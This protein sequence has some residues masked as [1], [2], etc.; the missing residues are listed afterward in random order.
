MSLR[1]VWT[2]EAMVAYD[3]IMNYLHR[4]WGER[5]AD[6]FV[7]DVSHTIN[8]LEIFPN[9]GVVEVAEYGIRSIPVAKQVRLFYRADGST[10]FVLEFID[11]RTERFQRIRS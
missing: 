2:P 4:E 3:D 5:V 8:L 9:M 7:E 10:L 1:S 11:T 6:A